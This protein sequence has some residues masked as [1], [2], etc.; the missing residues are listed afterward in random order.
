M[1]GV[2][3]AVAVVADLV[4]TVV[5][6]GAVAEAAVNVAVH[7]VVARDKDAG[8]DAAASAV[9]EPAVGMFAEDAGAGAAYVGV[10][11]VERTWR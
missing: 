1:L 11:A 4:G 8:Y 10:A 9:M 2:D 6:S 7:V 5:E 3:A